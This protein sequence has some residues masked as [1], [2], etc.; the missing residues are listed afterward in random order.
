MTEAVWLTSA[1]PRPMLRYLIGTDEVRVQSVEAFPDS[2]GSNRKLRLFACACYHRLD[3]LLPHP[4]ARAAVQVAERFADGAAGVAEFLQAGAGVRGLGADLEPRWRA[5]VGEERAAL[6]PT[7]AALALAGVACWWEP[8]KAAWYAASN[9]HL[10]YP[11]LADPGVGVH[12]PERWEGELAERR[13][14]SDLIREV[15]GNPFRAGRFDAAWRTEAAVALAAG[16]YAEAAFDR[17]PVLADALEDA[18]CADPDILS[19][20]RGDGPHVRGCWVV[21]L[22]LGK[23]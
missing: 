20:C 14:Q 5:S 3:H 1:D 23:G 15:F 7:H 21:D 13:A 12:S 8:Q 2:R 9:A 11:Y 16:I 6:H 10:E 4:A 17:L 22:V 18:G 19:H